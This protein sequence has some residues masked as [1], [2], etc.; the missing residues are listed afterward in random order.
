MLWTGFIARH[1]FGGSKTRRAPSFTLLPAAGLATG[2]AALIVVLGVMNG[3]Q[4][5]YIDAI[6]EVS[7]FHLRI[8]DW[9]NDSP[10]GNA[11][12]LAAL[13]G[14]RSVLPF[15][16]LRCMASSSARSGTVVTLRALDKQAFTR[17]AGLASTL[18]LTG[19][20]V[21]K[22]GEIILGTEL[23][24]KLEAF[25]GDYVSVVT[26]AADSENGLSTRS[27]RFK[28]ADTFRSG[29]YEFDS[30]LALVGFT[31]LQNLSAVPP[32]PEYGIKLY[33]R[34]S[35]AHA[36]DLLTR[37]GVNPEKIS[38]WREYNRSFFGA[39]R[40]EKTIMMLL[41]GL[42]FL[43]V[44]V[45]IAH[46]MK[47]NV[48]QRTTEI[49][50]LRALGSRSR[51]VGSIFLMN[52]LAIG[53]AGAG[54][55]VV[56]GL[57]IVFNIN[58]IFEMAG[59]VLTFFSSLFSRLSGG[60]SRDLRIFSPAYFYLLEVPVRVSVAETFFVAASAVA[61]STFAAWSAIR[62][63]SGLQPAAVLRYE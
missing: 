49:A 41:V 8:S 20:S 1:W 23:S 33:N 38:S 27:A 25:P 9:P 36:F 59:T 14:V 47:R 11:S 60:E 6:L 53:L 7:S 17:D 10:E 32:V 63:L 45:N 29:Y 51:D 5:G 35:D 19:K 54:I 28:V 12:M 58:G 40:T 26:V 50:V 43:V 4:G 22:S 62:R 2:V 31:E 52:G 46:A 57:T 3:F 55:G 61:S 37:S 21:P 34:Y 15:T 42:I 39:L 16:D 48:A 24:R 13:P 44:G 30:T 56:A 18:D